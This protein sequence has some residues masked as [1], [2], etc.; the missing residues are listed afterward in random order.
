RYRKGFDYRLGELRGDGGDT[1]W[2]FLAVQ[3]QKIERGSRKRR[4]DVVVGRVNEHAHNAR[5]RRKDLRNATR[6]LAAHI[7]RARRK[8]DQPRR[9]RHPRPAPLPRRPGRSARKSSLG[10]SFAA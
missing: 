2:R 4:A 6:L 7:S 8:E 1:L 9:K 5:A 3:L 10:R